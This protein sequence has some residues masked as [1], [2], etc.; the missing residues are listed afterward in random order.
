MKRILLFTIMAVA[1]MAATAQEETV[2]AELFITQNKDAIITSNNSD[3]E[4]I[5]DKTSNKIIFLIDRDYFIGIPLVEQEVVINY[6]DSVKIAQ[7][8]LMSLFLNEGSSLKITE[9]LYELEDKIRK[10]ESVFVELPLRTRGTGAL[11]FT[12]LRNM[13]TGDYCYFK[14]NRGYKKD[15]LSKDALLRCKKI[16][17]MDLLNRTESPYWE[18]EKTK[19]YTYVNI[20]GYINIQEED[21]YE[22]WIA[23]GFLLGDVITDDNDFI[24]CSEGIHYLNRMAYTITVDKEKAAIKIG[25]NGKYWKQMPDGTIKAMPDGDYWRVEHHGGIMESIE[26]TTIDPKRPKG[27]YNL[28]GDKLKEITSPGIYIINGEKILKK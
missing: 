6:L 11:Y 2:N 21:E 16:E 5:D 24:R 8:S 14:Y 19:K 26:E 13:R 3:T 15:A 17:D 18:F 7:S 28:R 25:Q 9:A 22:Y 10:F 27:I 4:E 23:D 1:T 20:D 12:T